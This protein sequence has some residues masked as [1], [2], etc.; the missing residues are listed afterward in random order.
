MRIAFAAAE[1]VP[2][3][4]TGGL[5]DVCGALP[6]ALVDLGHDLTV[7]TPYHRV[8]DEW[9]DRSEARR[10]LTVETEISWAYWRAKVR[11]LRS[12]IPGTEIPVIFVAN[13]LFD[14]RSIYAAVESFDD[15]LE[16]FTL[17]GRAAIKALELIGQKVDIFH[18]HD[19]HT[20]AIPAW[21]ESGLRSVEVFR[22]T[23]TVFTIHNLHYQGRYR[24]DRFEFLGL[25]SRF[26]PSFE[27]FGALNLMKAGIIHANQVTTVSPQYA[28]EIMTP[29]Q[30]AE[31]DGLLRHVAPKVTGILNGIDVDDWNPASDPALPANYDLADL[32][33]KEVCRRS[34]RHELG[35]AAGEGRPLIGIVS[36][37]AE[38]K[39]LDLLIPIIPRL[40][41]EG[42]QFAILGS[43]DP[44]LEQGFRHLASRFGRSLSYNS[45][46]NPDLARRITAGTD[47]IAMPSR[48][49]P[50][51]LNQMYGLR[52][53]SLP[54]VRFTGG[55]ADSVIPYTGDN[56]ESATGFAFPHP[57]SAD[58]YE[59]IGAAMRVFE[60]RLIWR[61]LQDN[62]M[63]ADFSWTVA[64]KQYEKV[65][66]RAKTSRS[67]S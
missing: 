42:A 31:L 66:E 45:E 15:D 52:Y 62:A 37:L 4:K 56:L 3:S 39:G 9:F 11:L 50:C 67:S 7:V 36:R 61:R 54:L 22:E 40:V 5:A 47:L 38:Q 65:Y 20:G 51:G 25:E 14:R 60:N 57:N 12:T 59:T 18:I 2:F 13:E 21:L 19:W 49:E 6:K 27:F 55:L 23:A 28:R 43:G 48:Y 46:F 1:V 16:R 58:L 26:W 8:V 34:L 33:G 24:A 35:L 41:H 17:F 44:R 64:A 63:K 32:R 29:A 53:G 30:G 10:E